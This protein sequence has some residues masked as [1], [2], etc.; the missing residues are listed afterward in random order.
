MLKPTTCKNCWLL[1]LFS[2][3]DR[4]GNRRTV[5]LKN[6]T[7]EFKGGQCLIKTGEVVKGFYCIKEG[8][9]K[10]FNSGKRKREFILWIAEQGELLCV[11]S[12]INNEK[13]VFSATAID[14]VTTC[15]FGTSHMQSIL[16]KEPLIFNWLMQKLCNKLDFIEN[17]ITSISTR[18][19]KE[20]CA[21]MLHAIAGK[22]SNG[23]KIELSLNYSIS[24]LAS[25]TGTTK[26]YIYKIVCVL[27]QVQL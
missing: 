3:K 11:N 10:V 25:L 23:S 4:L 16:Q 20:R 24:D 21:E 27:N 18:N 13:S 1:N 15:F 6:Q 12:I 7:K 19:T 9:V 17:R 26:N 22:K 14:N 8:R 5:L 2:A